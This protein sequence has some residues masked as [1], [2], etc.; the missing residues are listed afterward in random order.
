MVPD[1][2]DAD[3]S[4]D[5]VS[6]LPHPVHGRD[7]SGHPT[8]PPVATFAG[9]DHGLIPTVF[10]PHDDELTEDSSLVV[11]AYGVPWQSAVKFGSSKTPART[12]SNYSVSIP[13]APNERNAS[14]AG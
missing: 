4:G 2:V 8:N 13:P 12:P 10:P 7:V 11:P 5:R 14:R 6:L 3:H 1:P 9:G